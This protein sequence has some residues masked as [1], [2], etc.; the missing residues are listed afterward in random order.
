MVKVHVLFF[1]SNTR[2][3][4]SFL[5]RLYLPT[6][7]FPLQFI[8]FYPPPCPHL[9]FLDKILHN[10]PFTGCELAPIAL[11]V[12]LWDNGHVPSISGYKFVSLFL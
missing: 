2:K 9:S 3:V 6:C 12:I 8:F 4:F 5:E 1:G 11:K 7:D 10:G